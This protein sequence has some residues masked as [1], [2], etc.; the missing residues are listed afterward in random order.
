[1]AGEVLMEG[2]V[3][4]IS[5]VVVWVIALS[6]LLTFGLTIWNMMA[7]GSRSNAKTLVEHNDRFNRHE[8]RLSS[9]EQ[10]LL[11]MPDAREL[12]ALHLGMSELRGELQVTRAVMEGNSHLMERLEAIVGRHEEHLLQGG[13]R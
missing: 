1:M 8:G 9:I 13:K 2:D 4:N 7:S 3:L 6:Q 5:P 11:G 10:T 12:H